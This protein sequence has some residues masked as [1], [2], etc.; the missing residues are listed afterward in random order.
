MYREYRK[1][2]ALTVEEA[3]A[4]IHIGSRT[5]N[6]YEAGDGI[7]TPD[8][9]LGMAKV[10]GVPWLTQIYCKECCAIGQA[11][12]YEIL[13]NVNLDP[14]SIMLKLITEMQEAQDSLSRLLQLAVNKNSMSDFKPE[15]WREFCS[16]LHEFLDVVHNIETLKISLGKWCDVSELIGQH[17]RKCIDKGYARKEVRAI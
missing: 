8:V 7:P 10:Y 2:A 3:A 6:K 9:V 4:R 5:L 16:C 11:Y 17:N 12:S 1:N 15:E 13:D 14:A